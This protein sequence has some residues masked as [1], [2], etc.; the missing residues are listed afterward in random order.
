MQNKNNTRLKLWFPIGISLR[1]I[2]RNCFRIASNC[3]ESRSNFRA[4]VGNLN[5]KF[6]RESEQLS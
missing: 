2:A 6:C 5:L 4:C 3:A 1:E